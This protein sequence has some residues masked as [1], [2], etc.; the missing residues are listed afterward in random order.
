MAFYNVLP[1][2]SCDYFEFVEN[3]YPSFYS[4][5]GLNKG[6][7]FLD[8][9]GVPYFG[10]VVSSYTFTAGVAPIFYD[11][12]V[13]SD[14]FL[15]LRYS[16]EGFVG[17][18]L[19]KSDAYAENKSES[20][21]SEEDV[22]YAS[23]GGGAPEPSNEIEYNVVGGENV[24]QELTFSYVIYD[25]FINRLSDEIISSVV[26]PYLYLGYN[27]LFVNFSP[28]ELPKLFTQID[29]KSVECDVFDFD[30][31]RQFKTDTEETF[32]VVYGRNEFEIKILIYKPSFNIR[33]SLPQ[34]VE[35]DFSNVTLPSNLSI[36]QDT[37]ELIVLYSLNE[38]QRV[39]L[40]D[41]DGNSYYID[42]IP[43]EA[44]Y[45]SFLE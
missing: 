31:L 35:F 37:K 42:I 21:F 22:A 27:S 2:G 3:P 23:N 12:N 45:I 41:S 14:I 9:L 18:N 29:T 40:T 6:S 16:F 10:K 7:I 1:V 36:N 11:F 44:D 26:E 38:P 25:S 20:F 4:I 13:D 34:D 8:V 43:T 19:I 15:N 17:I 39:T 33:I 5:L 24:E 28:N 32:E 30:N